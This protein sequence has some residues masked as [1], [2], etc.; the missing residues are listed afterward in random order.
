M[1]VLS[2]NKF[3]KELPLSFPVSN[4]QFYMQK[5]ALSLQIQKN[6]EKKINFE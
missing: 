3:S 5:T 2:T 4:D 6:E 1:Y